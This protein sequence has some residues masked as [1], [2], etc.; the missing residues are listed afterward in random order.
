MTHEQHEEFKR[1][2]DELIKWLADNVDPHTKAIVDC[3]SAELVEGVVVH[4]ND[5]HL[6]D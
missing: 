2:A 1:V 5:E 3:T 6:K 4:R